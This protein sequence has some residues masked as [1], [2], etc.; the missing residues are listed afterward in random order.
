MKDGRRFRFERRRLDWLPRCRHSR[1]PPFANYA[2]DGAP[3]VVIVSAVERPGH[4]PRIFMF[5]TSQSLMITGPRSPPAASSVV[6]RQQTQKT[7]NRKCREEAQ[8]T[9]GE[10]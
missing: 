3:T 7:A 1:F 2:K 10:G 4:P 6:G 9:L 5:K 8:R